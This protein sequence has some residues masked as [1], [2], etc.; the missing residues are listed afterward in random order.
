MNEMATGTFARIYYLLYVQYQ[1]LLQ[2]GEDNPKLKHSFNYHS[3]T[4]A[5]LLLL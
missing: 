3:V 2:L 1:I 4:K 5:R